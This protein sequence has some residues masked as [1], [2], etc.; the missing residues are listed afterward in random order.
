MA[1]RQFADDSGIMNRFGSKFYLQYKVESTM[2]T[3]GN[4]QL[5][6]AKYISNLDFK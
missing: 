4:V 5:L 2:S 3:M 1:L 6:A